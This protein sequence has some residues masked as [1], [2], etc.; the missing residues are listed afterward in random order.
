MLG[1]GILSEASLVSVFANSGGERDGQHSGL[2]SLQ[3]IRGTSRTAP[4]Y[5]ASAVNCGI[6]QVPIKMAW[7]VYGVVCSRRRE[8]GD[9]VVVLEVPCC[10]R[11][12][13]DATDDGF[14]EGSMMIAKVLTD[15]TVT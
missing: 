6:L 5:S 7:P 11:L 10:N 12:S 4:P 2:S 13:L 3:P 15:V 14:D 8:V 1:V 9:D